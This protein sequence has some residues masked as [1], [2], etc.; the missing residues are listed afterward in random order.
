MTTHSKQQPIRPPLHSKIFYIH[1]VLYGYMIY[2]YIYVRIFPASAE[3]LEYRISHSWICL[4]VAVA[5]VTMRIIRPRPP[6]IRPPAI[7]VLLGYTQKKTGVT[8][9]FLWKSN[10][11][12]YRT[13]HPLLL[14]ATPSCPVTVAFLMALRERS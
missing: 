7:I 5:A 4:S 14:V 3:Q 9:L 13:C 8:D 11:Q 6:V 10:Q 1:T 2:I 12:I